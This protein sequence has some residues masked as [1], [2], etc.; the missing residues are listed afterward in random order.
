MK[1]D[2][3]KNHAVVSHEEWLAARTAFLEKEK[4]RKSTRLN[5]SHLGISYA[6]FCLKKKKQKKNDRQSHIPKRKHSREHRQTLG[7]NAQDQTAIIP[8]AKSTRNQSIT[9]H[10]YSYNLDEVH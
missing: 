6:V 10:Y 3:V 7:H 4:D 1:T 2:S 9:H 5:S 8:R